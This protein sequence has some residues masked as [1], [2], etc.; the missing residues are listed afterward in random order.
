MRLFLIAVLIVV[1]NSGCCG[2]GQT[3]QNNSIH[4][5]GEKFEVATIKPVSP[6]GQHL[7]GVFVYPGG[8][9]LLSGM[10]LKDLICAAFNLS[11]W[12]LS[13]GESWMESI[14]YDV[15]AKPP[16]SV[17]ATHPY[18][19]HDLY[20]IDDPQI[21]TMLQTLLIERFHLK[22]HSEKKT[23]KV[24]LLERGKGPL[25]LKQVTSSSDGTGGIGF[26]GTWVIS[27]MTMPQLAKFA[28][29]TFLHRPVLDKT[30]LSGSYDF[31]SEPE[32]WESYSADTSG[33]FID[34][35]HEIGLRLEPA[36]GNVEVF[37]IDH[38]E[39]PSPN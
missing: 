27:N 8:R 10:S 23:G 9:V 30:D 13:G 21:R 35:I 5:E 15:V 33:S 6:H 29:S 36:Q 3:V 37:V 17:E 1:L 14:K 34:L 28:G 24:F 22:Y 26:A 25:R 7:V 11:Y 39:Q 32:S 31:R 18:T 12:Q 19:G 4:K 16:D 20:N 2:F 38:A